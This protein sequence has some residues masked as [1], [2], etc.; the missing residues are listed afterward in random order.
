[1]IMNSIIKLLEI[2]SVNYKFTTIIIAVLVVL[3]FCIKNAENLILIRSTLLTPFARFAPWAKRNQVA[4]K[5]RGTILKAVSKQMR[6]NENI[7]PTDLKVVWVNEEH[8]IAFVDNNQVIVR[9]KQSSNPNENLITAVSEYVNNGLLYNVRRYLHTDVIEASK[10]YMTRKIIQEAGNTALTYLDENYIMPTLKDNSEL[11]DLYKRLVKIDHN[12]MFIGILLNEFNKAGMS[13]YGEIEDP[14]LIAESKEFV[15]YLYDIAIGAS[16][17]YEKLCFNRDYFKVAIFLTASDRT[18][19]RAGIKPFIRAI[20]R[21]LNEGI[22]TIY[23]F[24]LGSKREVAEMISH[25]ASED[26]RVNAVIKHSY[27]HIG[28]EGRRVSGVFYECSIFKE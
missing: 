24:G 2:F 26:I 3:G 16:S 20:S 9:I 5:V 13:I 11:K 19:K 10:T 23:V 7:L 25:E 28:M 6:N 21:K 22:E 27:K 18:L 17:D 8:P 14:E 1:M 12:G 15:N 4:S